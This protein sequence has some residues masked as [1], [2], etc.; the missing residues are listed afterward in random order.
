MLDPAIPSDLPSFREH[1]SPSLC[2]LSR[3]VPCTPLFPLF[4]MPPSPPSLDASPHVSSAPYCLQLYGSMYSQS[5]NLQSLRRFSLNALGFVAHPPSLFPPSR[6]LMSSPPSFSLTAAFLCPTPCSLPPL[7][8][9][10]FCAA[11]SS[12]LHSFHV[13]GGP[14]LGSL[15]RSMRMYFPSPLRVSASRACMIPIVAWL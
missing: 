5:R 15:S 14:S 9:Y 1:I 7:L 12:N 3:F 11:L 8:N 4:N 13:H 6:L 2:C 10:P